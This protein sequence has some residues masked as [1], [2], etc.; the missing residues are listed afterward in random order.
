MKYL[1]TFES[2][3]NNKFLFHSTNIKHLKEIKEYGLIPYFGDTV[4]KA[5]G[6]YYN[7]DEKADDYSSIDYDEDEKIKLKYNGLIFFSETP[8]LKYSQP[9]YS[10][11]FIWEEALLCII[12]KNESIFKKVDDYPR[13][14]DFENKPIYSYDGIDFRDDLVSVE[15]NDWFSFEQQE[16]WKLIY[17]ADLYKYMKIKYPLEFEQLNKEKSGY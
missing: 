6:S 5:Y 12:I 1:K 15:T 17:G 16:P 8:K 14:I 2:V 9:I 7:F 13:F 11:K 3:R 4:R 10:N